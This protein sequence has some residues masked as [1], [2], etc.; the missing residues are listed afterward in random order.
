MLFMNKYGK[1]EREEVNK[2]LNNGASNPVLEEMLDYLA[3]SHNINGLV[4][5][6]KYIDCS[7]AGWYYIAHDLA[8]VYLALSTDGFKQV[9][10]SQDNMHWL[11]QQLAFVRHWRAN[12]VGIEAYGLYY[13]NGVPAYTVYHSAHAVLS[14]GLCVPRAAWSW[15]AFKNALKNY[16]AIDRYASVTPCKLDVPSGTLSKMMDAILC[17][18]TAYGYKVTLF[19]TSFDLCDEGTRMGNCIASYWD[20]PFSDIYIFA[21]D[22]KGERIDVE[23]CSDWEI[24]QCYTRY[25]KKT[26][27]SNDLHDILDRVIGAAQLQ[28]MRS[29]GYYIGLNFNEH[30]TERADPE[31]AILDPETGEI[32]FYVY[33]LPS[34]RILEDTQGRISCAYITYVRV[35]DEIYAAYQFTDADDTMNEFYRLK[36]GDAALVDGNEYGFDDD[37]FDDD[38]DFE[39][40]PQFDDL[41]LDFE[42]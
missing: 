32:L 10:K 24:D 23:I 13:Q 36:H 38:D 22:Y 25:N 34:G 40:D 5:I 35:G 28:E 33:D 29:T 21:V 8:V 17:K 39:F 12:A 3:S 41:D 19:E 14:G 31:S 7:D 2:I 26:A 16:K 20:N 11:N 1:V 27:I 37:D 15:K 9:V 18:E 6:R 30:Q 4:N 42:F